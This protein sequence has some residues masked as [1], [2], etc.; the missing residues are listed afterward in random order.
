MLRTFGNLWTISKKKD[1]W[2]F[3]SVTL[4]ATKEAGVLAAACVISERIRNDPL[5]HL[6]LLDSTYT[7]QG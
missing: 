2:L 7:T 4:H 5:S 6:V 1:G 3:C